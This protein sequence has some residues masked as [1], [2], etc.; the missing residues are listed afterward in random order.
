M[1]ILSNSTQINPVRVHCVIF[2]KI[3]KVYFPCVNYFIDLKYFNVFLI[4]GEW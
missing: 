2:N 3:E 1:S 4:N